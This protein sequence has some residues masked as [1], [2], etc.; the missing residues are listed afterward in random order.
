MFSGPWSMKLFYLGYFSAMGV[1]L[2]YLSLYLG[3]VG[4]SGTQIGLIASIFPL[5]GVV[6]PPVWGWLSDHYGWRKRLLSAALLGA[7]ITSL[8]IWL[9]GHSFV[10]LL[11]FICLLAISLSPVIP[12]AD[13]ISLHWIEQWG[14]SY[15]AIRVYGSAGFLIVAIIAGSILNAVGIAS[16]FLLLGG[17]FC[18]PL[19]ASFFVPSQSKTSVAKL[20][21]R[22]LVVLLRD[23]KL[24]LFLLLCMIGYGTFAAYNT[25]F[26]L[27][28]RSLGVSTAQIGL[29]SGMASL[30]ELPLMVFS[31][32]LMKRL[33]VQW[34]LLIGLSVAVVRWLGYAFFTD[35]KVL[36]VFTLLHGISFASF[37]VAAVTYID[38]RVPMHMRTTG[39]TLL[40]GTSF[41][42][43]TWI[44]NN[45]FGILYERLHGSGMFLVAAAICAASVVGLLFL[46]SRESPQVR[47]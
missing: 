20:K 14:G 15:G 33:G 9:L 1:Y 29:A 35:Y 24:L 41:G 18:A 6:M 16:L 8:F 30:S 45:V 47:E 23:R 13:A 11:I 40:Y 27:Y 4:L 17:V 3:A 12:L 7:V 22:E 31:G 38:R 43:G 26:G 10:A 36:F 28:L 46:I 44:S 25:F 19:L 37:Y 21:G 5:A 39:Q 32:F 34:L 2:P 42:F